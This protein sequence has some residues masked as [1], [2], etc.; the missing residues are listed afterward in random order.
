MRLVEV[1]WSDPRGLG[2]GGWVKADEVDD[3]ELTASRCKTVG[4]VFR[5][6]DD[7][8]VLF[9]SLGFNRGEVE[10]VGDGLVIPK[11]VVQQVNDLRR[12]LPTMVAA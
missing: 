1:F 8:L 2:G 4:Y 3:L 10:E 7:E 11:C 5:E 6:T 12:D 9:A